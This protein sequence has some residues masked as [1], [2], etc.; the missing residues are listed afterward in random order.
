M[1]KKTSQD[2]GHR[3]NARAQ[4]IAAVILTAGAII[5]G[6][7]QYKSKPGAS[8]PLT[9]KHPELRFVG[10]VTS[11]DTKA[12]VSD[13]EV[14][15][16][17]K[18][19]PSVTRTDSKGIFSFPLDDH[20][21]EVRIRVQ[22][23]GYENFVQRIVPASNTGIEDIRIRPLQKG[24]GP[25]PIKKMITLHLVIDNRLRNGK[26]FVDGKQVLSNTDSNNRTI[27][28]VGFMDHEIMVATKTDT[29]RTSGYFDTANKTISMNCK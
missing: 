11:I 19:V 7:W 20:T 4:I 24:P 3:I 21:R 18:D 26:V 15:F 17:N 27:E 23:A 5:V 6:W 22:A 1:S 13:A 9:L 14:T 29:C 12:P 16:E 8:E 10:R 2:S 25:K 28:V